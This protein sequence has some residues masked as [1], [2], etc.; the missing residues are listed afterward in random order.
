MFKNLPSN[1]GDTDLIP[2]QRNKIL[3]VIGKLESPCCTTREAHYTREGPHAASKSLHATKKDPGQ[4][5]KRDT[6]I[7]KFTAALFTIAKVCCC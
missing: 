2:D 6:H 5:K 1:A 3:Y 4:P 7:P